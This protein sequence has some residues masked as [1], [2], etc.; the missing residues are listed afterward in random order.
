VRKEYEELLSLNWVGE[1]GKPGLL[2][3]FNRGLKRQESQTYEE[4]FR[5]ERERSQAGDKLEELDSESV[6]VAS[7]MREADCVAKRSI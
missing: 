2:A 5:A 1:F 3:E 7:A 6:L 4:Q